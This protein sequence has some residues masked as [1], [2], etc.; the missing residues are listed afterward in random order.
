MAGARQRS[1]KVNPVSGEWHARVRAGWEQLTDETRKWYEDFSRQ[2]KADAV[3][4]RARK[5]ARVAEADQEFLLQRIQDQGPVAAPIAGDEAIIAAEAA[6][7]A[8]QTADLPHNLLVGIPPDEPVVPAAPLSL[9]A[10]ALA[11][12]RQAALDPGALSAFFDGRPMASIYEGF[13]QSTA[14][15]LRPP[16][17]SR[18]V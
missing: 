17:A 14:R 11:S 5:R 3:A 2:S 4:A 7:T 8:Q 9:G 6:P 13:N 10:K 18:I 1:E 15:L 16:I 12:L